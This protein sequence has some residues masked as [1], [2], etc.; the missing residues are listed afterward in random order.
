[1]G[2]YRD[3]VLPRLV[4]R[5]CGTA[6]LAR[7]RAQVTAGLSGT[8]VEVGF[9]SGLNMP[10]YP[11]E[12]TLVYAVEPA[13]TARRL[14][15]RRIADAE[16][17]VE[18]VSLHG[19]S[20]ELDDDSCDGALSTFTLCTIPDVGQALS[21]IRRVLRPGGR[22]HFL[23]HGLSPDAGIARWQHRI[24]PAQKLF[25]GGC[26]LTRRPVE[27]VA[28][29]GFRIERVEARYGVGPKPWSWFT[30]GVAVSP[31]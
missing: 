1:M 17:P 7:W 14:A 21:E 25:A 3:H 8:V 15:A 18:H 16:I 26:H 6:E 4:D 12:V 20:I 13:D 10:A 31:R 27:L 23:E 29:A 11:P 30:E 28:A 22:L 24:E 5:A 19:E 2:L 9:G